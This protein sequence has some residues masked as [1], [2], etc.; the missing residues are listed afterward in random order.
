MTPNTKFVNSYKEIMLGMI[1]FRITFSIAFIGWPVK[2]CF[3]RS[4]DKL[5]DQY[6]TTW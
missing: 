5:G 2:F 4:L 3:A 1:A 6:M